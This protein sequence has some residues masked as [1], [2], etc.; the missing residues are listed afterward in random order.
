MTALTLPTYLPIAEAARKYGMSVRHL[1]ALINDGTIKAAMVMD[2]LVVDEDEVRAKTVQRKEDLPEYKKHASLKGNEIGLSEAANKYGVNAI[3]IFGWFKKG[4]ISEIR[5]VTGLGG[6][7][8]LLDE[9]DVAY[10]VEVYKS[11]GGRQGKRVFDEHGMPYK[12][13]TGRLTKKAKV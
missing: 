4:I 2:N 6:E 11:I 7:K 13:G 8:I 3:T 12:P 1:K 10:C 5:R 9:A